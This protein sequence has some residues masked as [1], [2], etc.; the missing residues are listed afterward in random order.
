MYRSAKLSDDLMHRWV[1][2]C[3]WN[4]SP[5]QRI[6]V[7]V[8]LNPSTA[9]AEKDDPTSQR[10]IAFAKYWGY[11]GVRIVNL[12]SFR[13]T[14]PE[15]MY[16]WFVQQ[17]L[18]VLQTHAA[19]ALAVCMAKDTAKVVVAHGKLHDCIKHHAI[20]TLTSIQKFRNLHSIKLN[21]DGSPAHPLYLKGDL[22]PRLYFV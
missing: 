9:T 20:A 1:F 16:A 10:V 4:P 22:T 8:M 12:V 18:K 5:K 17:P 19:A 7:F 13:A 11:D 15:H 3:V 2:E 6:C 14:Q 21:K